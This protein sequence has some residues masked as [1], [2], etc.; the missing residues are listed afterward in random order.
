MVR[1]TLLA[2]AGAL[3][4]PG[5]LSASIPHPPTESVPPIVGGQTSSHHDWMGLLEIQ[6]ASGAG[7]WCGGSLIAPGIVLTA[8]HCVWQDKL[9]TPAQV[10]FTSYRYNLAVTPDAEGAIQ[11]KATAVVAHP[12]YNKADSA[13]D[14]AIVAVQQA[15]NFGKQ[16]NTFA[17][18]VGS[19]TA[20]N[21]AWDVGVYSATGWGALTEGGN[22]AQVLQEVDLPA[23][24]A[25]TCAR[26]VSGA[27]PYIANVIC[28]GKEGK[29]SC[30][31][32]SGGPLYV[33][34]AKP[35]L[36][37]IVSWGIGCARKDNPGIYTRVGAYKGWI[38]ENID[39]YGGGGG[40]GGGGSGGA[41]DWEKCAKSSDCKSKCCTSEY[42]KPGAAFQ[43]KCAPNGKKCI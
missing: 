24:D 31:G 18:W 34:G 42:S 23:V 17:D 29:D 39:K 11:W 16:Q 14:V 5:V 9:A 32:D 13:N 30:Q 7:W 20:G 2:T 21:V 38:Q 8:A 1:L 26:Q 36:Y 4:A 6:D 19:R 27:A 33:K 22:T 28:A 37:G 3:L 35:M 15:S 40:G 12:G 25:A 10:K 41:G 43:Y